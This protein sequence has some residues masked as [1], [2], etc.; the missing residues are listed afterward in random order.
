MSYE[1]DPTTPGRVSELD[2]SKASVSSVG[3]R[4]KS[5]KRISE[6]QKKFTTTGESKAVDMSQV[7]MA[8]PMSQSATSRKVL[9]HEVKVWLEANVVSFRDF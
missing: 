5:G 2:V 8:T 3:S 4:R 6:L 7:S 1:Q 9:D